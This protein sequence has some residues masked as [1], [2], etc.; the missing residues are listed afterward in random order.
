MTKTTFGATK[1]GDGQFTCGNQT[2]IAAEKRKRRLEEEIEDGRW[3][4]QPKEDYH[5]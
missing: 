4:K 1:R 5:R 2:S 3:Q